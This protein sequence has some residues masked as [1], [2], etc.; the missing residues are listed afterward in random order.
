[1]LKPEAVKVINALV[2]ENRE[3]IFR[4][5]DTIWAHPE[6]GYREW[7]TSAFMEEIFKGLGYTPITMG[8]IPGFYA[9]LDTGRPGPVL[10]IIGE[11]DSVLCAGHPEADPETGA[12]HACGH[13]T[14][15][16]N[17]VGSAAVLRKIAGLS[18][19]IRF[20]S[21]PAEETI[22]LGFRAKLRDKGIIKFYTGKAEFLYRGV[23][24]GVDA[25]VM[26][27]SG[28]AQDKDFMVTPGN[29]GFLTKQ[30]AYIGKAAHAGEGPHIG[31]NALYA[32][33]L[34]MQAINSIRETFVED[35]HTRVHPIITAGGT[36]VNVIPENV[37]METFVRGASPEAIVKENKKVNRALAGA[38]LAMGARVRVDDLPGCLPLHNDDGMREIAVSVGKQLLGE[39]R[40]ERNDFW[41]P[42][43]TDMGDLSCLMPVVHP[44]GGGGTGTPHGEDYHTAD[45]ETACLDSTRLVAGIATALLSNDGA[46]LYEIK[47]SFHP[48]FDSR[49]DYFKFL[50]ALTSSRDLVNY[51]GETAVVTW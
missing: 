19:K 8:D 20:I 44:Y 25:A 9:E 48:V 13:H 32:A 2:E 30:I 3:L 47:N 14:Q 39:N 28:T 12:V 6:T 10:A 18:G 11:L 21:V 5:A 34:G 38:A 17:L 49:D 40:I 41:V 43:S 33:S 31:I 15:S 4:T 1:M 27:H 35:N 26:V 7:K 46:A 50:D 45:R 51:N 36:A 24:D 37:T 22:E 16:A 23:F 29:N 42:G